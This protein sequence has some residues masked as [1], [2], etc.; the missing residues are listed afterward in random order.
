MAPE[1]TH[2]DGSTR[3]HGVTR[4]IS[5]FTSLVDPEGRNVMGNR[6]VI[7]HQGLRQTRP[8]RR[9]LQAGRQLGNIGLLR[10]RGRSNT[11]RQSEGT[12]GSQHGDAPSHTKRHDRSLESRK[13]ENSHGSRPQ[14]NSFG[15]TVTALHVTGFHVSGQNTR[16]NSKPE[17]ESIPPPQER[18]I[19]KD[20]EIPSGVWAD[21]RRGRRSA[22]GAPEERL[23]DH[24]HPLARA[25]PHSERPVR[26][27]TD[28]AHRVPP[29]S[30]RIRAA[31]R[32][33]GLE[34]T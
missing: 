13:L 22:A 9:G 20:P 28:R 6:A 17:K 4:R 1:T 25:P 15:V 10:L 32:P 30:S 7:P 26:A 33:V 3:L 5:V 11:Q 14:E 18:A 16:R 8:G 31:V 27:T 29:S 19:R 2:S 21:R 12:A 23:G 34:P 24:A